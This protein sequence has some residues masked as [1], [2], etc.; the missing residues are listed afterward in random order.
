M[1]VLVAIKQVAG[2]DS[3]L[4]PNTAGTWIEE[5]GLSYEVNEPDLYAL[6]AALQLKDKHGGEVVALCAGEDRV[7]A[8]IRDALAKGADRAIHVVTGSLS[9]WDALDVGRLLA[10]AAAAEAPDLV[11][12]GLQSNDLGQG[13]V[14]VI[15]AEAMGLPHATIIIEIEKTDCGVR[16]KRELEGGWYQQIELP[17]P[18]VVTVQSGIGQL[19][20]ATLM[21]VKRARTKEVKRITAE[22]FGVAPVQRMVIDRI[23]ARQSEKQTVFFEGSP[24]ETAAALA[25]R[26]L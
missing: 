25:E 14:G 18:A 15:M 19:R 24:R 1:K 26:I 17:L 12:S 10:R 22:E 21:G 6:E 23:Y 20:Y 13:Q 4:T 16:V 5:D 7:S 2:R 8:A 9:D 3:R 11:L